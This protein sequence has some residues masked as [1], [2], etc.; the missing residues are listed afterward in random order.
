MMVKTVL[1]VLLIC[2]ATVSGKLFAGDSITVHVAVEDFRNDDGVCR[3]L[4]Y[5]SKKG[6]P[7]SPEHAELMLG[8]NIQEKK[9]IFSFKVR[10]GKYA[11]SILHDENSNEEMDKTWYGKPK[12]GFGASNN[13]KIGFGPPEFEESTVKLDENNDSLKII[14]NYL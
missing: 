10:P 3:L 7:D 8:G 5:K 2:L 6:F 1:P 14:L 13:P 9:A 12:E 11:I 4:L